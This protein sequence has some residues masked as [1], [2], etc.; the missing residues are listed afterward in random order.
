M[1]FICNYF[2]F[3]CPPGRPANLSQELFYLLKALTQPDVSQ[4][5]SLIQALSEGDGRKRVENFCWSF[6]WPGND[7][8]DGCMGLGERKV[9][10]SSQTQVTYYHNEFNVCFKKWWKFKRKL[11]FGMKVLLFHEYV[12][13]K[14]LRFLIYFLIIS[15]PSYTEVKSPI[16]MSF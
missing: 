12:W 13:A 8:G 6:D 15:I 11:A 3:L 5:M 9:N 10:K 16:H 7:N 1:K 4:R 2:K 14:V